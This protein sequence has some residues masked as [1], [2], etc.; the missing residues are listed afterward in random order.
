MRW[1]TAIATVEWR[2]ERHRTQRPEAVV[3]AGERFDVEA[4][5]HWVEGP[6]VAGGPLATVFEVVAADGR[7]YRI[8][9]RGD[10]PDRVEVHVGGG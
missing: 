6:A 7:R 3:L 2:S 10:R 8:T 5:G 1:V 9:A 4:E